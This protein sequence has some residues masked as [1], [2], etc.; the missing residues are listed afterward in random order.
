VQHIQP[1]IKQG[2]DLKE[3]LIDQRVLISC[4]GELHISWIVSTLAGFL[5]KCELVRI[6]CGSYKNFIDLI[7]IKGRFKKF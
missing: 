7:K 4:N 1:I 5:S 6:Y 2:K 3:I